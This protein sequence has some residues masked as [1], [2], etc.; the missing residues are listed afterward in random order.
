MRD[1]DVNESYIFVIDTEMYSG[2]FE[3]EMCAFC[4]GQIGDCGS[5][6]ETAKSFEEEFLIEFEAF[7]EIIR[8]VPD[9]GCYRPVSI[10]TTP[11]YLNDGLG[12]HYKESEKGSEAV[13]IRY[14]KERAQH[15]DDDDDDKEPGE[16]QAYQS[17]AI[18]FDEQPSDE[19][20]SFMIKRAK[21]FKAGHFE[22]H[23]HEVPIIG[24][25]LIKERHTFDTIA[26]YT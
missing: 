5:G 11:G 3:R 20:V 4:T 16:F 23:K 12:G 25:R 9:D 13:R 24:F 8:N 10:Y 18:F 2:N 15:F 17:V 6:E 7:E 14:T 22:E 1:V 19:L 26:S 21:E